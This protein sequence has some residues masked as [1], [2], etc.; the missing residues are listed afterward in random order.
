MHDAPLRNAIIAR[1]KGDPA[2]TAIVTKRVYDAVVAK[3]VWPFI[4]YGFPLNE[5]VQAQGW[6]VESH[7]LTVHCFAKGPGRAEIDA[8]V[9]AVTR[10]LDDAEIE[11]DGQ[12]ALCLLQYSGLNVGRDTPE[13]DAYHAAVQFEAAT[14][15]VV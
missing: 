12:A 4:R 8:L 11:L 5:R 7:T 1:L 15:E 13:A 3:P 2:V 14:A 9:D 10:C 6:R